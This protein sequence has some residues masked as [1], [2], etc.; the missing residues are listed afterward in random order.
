MEPFGEG[1]N[2]PY[3]RMLPARVDGSGEPFRAAA[4]TNY[5]GDL[6]SEVA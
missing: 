4:R 2:V 5:E 6:T 1:A 3:L